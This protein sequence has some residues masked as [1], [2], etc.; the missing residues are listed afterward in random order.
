MPDGFFRACSMNMLRD[1]IDTGYFAAQI[2][3]AKIDGGQMEAKIIGTGRWN[4][5]Q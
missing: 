4:I 2:Q 1:R 3:P 5:Y